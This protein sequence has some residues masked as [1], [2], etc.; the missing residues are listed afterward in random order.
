MTENT[1]GA[2]HAANCKV[3]PSQRYHIDKSIYHHPMSS[4][5]HVAKSLGGHV[6]LSVSVVSVVSVIILFRNLRNSGGELWVVFQ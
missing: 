1:G 2:N 5:Q 4:R 3:T 6:I